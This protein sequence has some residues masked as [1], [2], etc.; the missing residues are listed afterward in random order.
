MDGVDAVELR[1]PRRWDIR[2]IRSFM[3]SVGP[4]SSI[5][6]FLTFYLMLQVFHAGEALFHTG[7][8]VESLAT[9]VLVIFVIRTRG[10]PFRSRPS[11]LLTATS[12]SAVMLAGLLPFTALGT[13][14]GFV[15]LPWG[16][17][18]A[19]GGDGGGLPGRAW[20]WSSAG[21]SAGRLGSYLSRCEARPPR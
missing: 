7:W 16:F 11:T 5:F 21:S 17:F 10:N 19:A 12:L 9:Q 6:D 15:P 18:L 8:F 20:R 4:V 3:L 1:R 2:F 13:R 14:L